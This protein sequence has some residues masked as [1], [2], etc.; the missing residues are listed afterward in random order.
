MRVKKI[1]NSCY[2]KREKRASKE[3]RSSRVVLRIKDQECVIA[4]VYMAEMMIKAL[5]LPTYRLHLPPPHP[6][7]NHLLPSGSDNFRICSQEFPLWRSRSKS[8]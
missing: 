7:T 8:D 1:P 4:T 6:E 5:G 2:G 3:N